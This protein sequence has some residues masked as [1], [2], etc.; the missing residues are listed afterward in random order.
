MSPEDQ[1][2]EL[3]RGVVDLH[4]GT[5]LLGL[6]RTGKP[7]KIKAGFDP[8][9]PDL[10]LGHTVL[11]S[12]MRQF[13]ELGHHVVF[14]VGDFTALIGDPSGRNAARPPA[15]AEQIAEGAKSYAAQAFKVL[16]PAR[17]EV[18]Y[19]SHWLGKMGFADVIRLSGRYTLARMMERDDF[20]KRYTEHVPISLHELLYP[21][22]QA[23][24]SVV[25]DCDVELGGTDQLFNLMVAR[26]I[27]K[28]MGMRPQVVMTTP[29]LEGLSARL[30]GGRIVGDKMS[31]SLDNYV[32]VTEAPGVQMG[33]LM[34]ISDDLMWR[35]YELLSARAAS[36]IGARRAACASGAMNP[37]DAK[38]DLAEEIITRYHGGPAANEA[39][40]G[41]LR[42]FSK[43][44]VEQRPE[45]VVTTT[46][47][48]FVGVGVAIA[49][50]DVLPSSSEA[51]RRIAAGGIKVEG[52]VI[53][54]PAFR[55]EARAESYAIEYRDTAKVRVPLRVRA[56]DAGSL[57]GKQASTPGPAFQHVEVV[58]YSPVRWP[59]GT[60]F[61]NS[62]AAAAS[63]LP[64][65]LAT[66]L[67]FPVLHGADRRP[68]ADQGEAWID[69]TR[70]RSGDRPDW[71][72]AF[73]VDG[74]LLLQR[75]LSPSPT[76]TLSLEAAIRLLLATLYVADAFVRAAADRRPSTV[77]VKLCGVAHRGFES[78]AGD[79][80][81]PPTA[82]G[83]PISDA[84]AAFELKLPVDAV[85]TKLTLLAPEIAARLRRVAGDLPRAHVD[86]IVER[87]AASLIALHSG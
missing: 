45:V 71:I 63:C 48:G 86:A 19:N 46:S 39:R 60:V 82:V 85:P 73:G 37:R 6:L 64:E 32:G 20:K 16:D 10:H 44:E 52:R 22:A 59:S 72:C 61:A 15:S 65:P 2:R 24:D 43:R 83:A 67:S 53:T 84:E 50:A 51:R 23:W 1:L 79:S 27:M 81:T 9:R 3:S 7:L 21:L 34:S 33:K 36:E 49:M 56:C 55:V 62:V 38:L 30:E 54:D 78:Q 29:I 68:V 66:A 26:E 5:D 57:L 31:K 4:V 13:Q 58:P 42:Q 69:P 28:E 41:W 77:L 18:A 12:K 35:Y 75:A 40:E 8:T 47:G 25:L 80:S 70:E 87:T 14:V 76:K 74:S 17:T 11:M